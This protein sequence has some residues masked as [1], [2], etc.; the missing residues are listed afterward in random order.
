MKT[1]HGMTLI[2]DGRIVQSGSVTVVFGAVIN[3][4]ENGTPFE[5]EAP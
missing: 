2:G 1:L 3:A 5:G 4:S